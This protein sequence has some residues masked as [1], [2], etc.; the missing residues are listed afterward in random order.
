V[1]NIKANSLNSQTKTYYLNNFVSGQPGIYKK[2]S[3]WISN[4]IDPHAIASSRDDSY[5]KYTILSIAQCMLAYADSEYTQDNAESVPRA[6]LLYEEAL[7]LLN[8]AG[9]R[10]IYDEASLNIT[11]VG[12]KIQEMLADEPEWLLVWEDIQS[13]MEH[14]KKKVGSGSSC[15]SNQLS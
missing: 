8:D 6:R 3:D 14:V 10:S 15:T 2:P 11:Q 7:D 13:D 12:L 4:P 1:F 9:I 5:L